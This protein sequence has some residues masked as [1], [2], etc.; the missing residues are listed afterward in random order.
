MAN[1]SAHQTSGLE[2]AIKRAW[3]EKFPKAG[4]T[5]FQ[6]DMKDPM[7]VESEPLQK[8]VGKWSAQAPINA[9]AEG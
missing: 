8:T 9:P 6:V 1:M 3:I 7:L 2:E 5:G 4:M